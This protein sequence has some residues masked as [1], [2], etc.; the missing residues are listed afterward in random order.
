MNDFV[1]GTAANDYNIARN[2]TSLQHDRYRYRRERDI[3]SVLFPLTRKLTGRY[4]DF[5]QS[6]HLPVGGK[7][8]FYHHF[9]CISFAKKPWVT[10]FEFTIPR[11]Y[12]LPENLYS[13]GIE[14]LTSHYCRKLI[15]LSQHAKKVQSL[16]LKEHFPEFH[17]P[18]MNKV[19][20]VLPAQPLKVSGSFPDSLSGLSEHSHLK[21][22][23]ASFTDRP[24]TF[25]LIGNDFFRKGGAAVLAAFE[26]IESDGLARPYRFNIISG[27]KIGDYATLATESDR[28]KTIEM[29]EKNENINW[30]QNIPNA[31][32]MDILRQS[33]ISLLPTF[34]D[35]FGYS[36]LEAQ[37][38]GCPVVTTNIQA[39]PEINNNSCG[40]VVEVPLNA[41]GEADMSTAQ[42]RE[43]TSRVLEDGL[44][45]TLSHILMH[46][47]D[48]ELAR[49]RQRCLTRIAEIH[50]PKR[51]SAQVSEIYDQVLAFI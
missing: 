39:L 32:V 29:I 15:A 12:G 9:N 36:V 8:D 41:Y 28:Q 38:T 43:T 2:I 30:Y 23:T 47:D 5:L 46:L 26:R 45:K 3:F 10:T 7:S 44:V 13:V 25:T 48:A 51:V 11:W 37:A 6:S 1:V 16:W 24:L 35:T 22:S 49:K 4:L 40:W 14:R 18:I 17:D 21:T 19:Q 34:A 20:V 27:L 31:Q 33:D 42:A 50:S